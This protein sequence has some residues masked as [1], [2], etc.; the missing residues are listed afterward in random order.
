MINEKLLKPITETKYLSVE[1]SDRYRSIIRLFYLKY[2]RLKYW[3]YQEEVY[4]ELKKEDYFSSYTIEQCQQDLKALAQW[5]NL[6]TIQDT[7]KVTSIEEFKNRKYR[8]QLSEYSVEIER[9][10]IKLENLSI[11]GASLEPNLL[12]RLRNYIESVEGICTKKSEDIYSWWND[13][14]NDF[15]RLNQNYQDYMR[16]LNSVKAEELMKTT[17][18]LIFKDRLTD[19]LRSFVKSLQ[20]NVPMIEERL[21]YLEETKI[22]FLLEKIIQYELSIPR[23]DVEISEEQIREKIKGRWTS[24]K[25]WF[26]G[27]LGRESESVKVFDTTN[28]I[29][30][31]IT[32]Y[33][34]RISERSNSGANRREEYYKLATMF[35]KCTDIEQAHRLSACVFGVEAPFHLKGDFVRK[36]ESINSGVYEEEPFKVQIKPRIRQYKEKASRSRI[37]DRS[38]EKELVRQETMRQLEKERKLFDSYIVDNRLEFAKLPTLEPQVRNIFLLWLSKALENKNFRGKT[39]DGRTYSIEN[40]KVKETCNIQCTDGYFTMPAYVMIFDG[41]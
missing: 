39:E 34:T 26:V 14:N 21:K 9:M 35:S 38:F 22:S 7:T 40:V 23:I 13:L 12:D 25:E 10:V 15:V 36:T 28:E 41:E 30:R 5:K 18:F 27:S 1:N 4:E 11:E 19:Y 33:A 16:D 37:I 6:I 3:M 24:I 8:Y 31:K 32:R 29:I 20:L 17:A 2:E